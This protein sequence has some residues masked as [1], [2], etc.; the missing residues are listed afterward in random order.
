MGVRSGANQAHRHE[1][2]GRCQ[3]S[4]PSKA[5]DKYSSTSSKSLNEIPIVVMCLK[6]LVLL[7]PF[8]LIDWQAVMLSEHRRRLEMRDHWSSDVCTGNVVRPSFNE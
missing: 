3:T 4:K 5:R 1:K 7:Q 6:L 2:K 8:M